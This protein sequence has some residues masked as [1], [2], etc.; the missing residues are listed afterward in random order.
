MTGPDN[1]TDDDGFA[2]F[3]LRA[4]D[5]PETET[6]SPADA[7]PPPE[8]VTNEEAAMTKVTRIAGRK[9]RGIGAW[10]WSVFTAFLGL[11]ISIAAYDYISDLM[12]R[13]PAIGTAALMLLVALV[14]MLL[15]QIGR[16]M[17]AF[18][19]LARI[20]S[21]RRD[22]ASALASAD[23]KAA[24]AL[25]ERLEQF[26]ASRSELAWGARSLSEGRAD[27]L[28]ADAIIALTE[29][30]LCGPLDLEARREVEAAART[31]AG[32][33]ALIPLALADVLSALSMNI[34]M[35]RR[36]AEVYGAHAGFFGSWRLLRSVATHLIA[37]GAVAVGDDFISSV[38]G[39]SMLTRISR[40]FGEGMVNGAL[41][42]RVGVAA[43]EVCRPLPFSA[44]D[45]PSVR[46]IMRRSV[47]GLFPDTRK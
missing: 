26:Y 27:M 1:K 44:L 35:I 9:R 38:A 21:F 2:P 34:R 8:D 12:I 29:R 42:A 17:L 14:L 22:S 47:T 20:D 6:S 39:G 4:S 5:L 25:S 36:I 32:V 43:M 23:H 15:I 30:S 13:F 33:T 28:D 3:V 45:R 16:E 11:V 10:F 46:G 40:R 37:T 24:H 18:R 31:V 41:T 19:R 7:P